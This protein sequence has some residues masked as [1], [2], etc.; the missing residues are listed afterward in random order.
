MEF[1]CAKGVKEASGILDRKKENEGNLE[2]SGT[3]QVAVGDPGRQ[4]ESR[5]RSCPEGRWRV[6]KILIPTD[7]YWHYKTPLL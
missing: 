3:E 1:T 4:Q 7:N 2:A 6:N 5:A